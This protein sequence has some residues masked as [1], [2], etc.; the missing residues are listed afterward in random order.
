MFK[1]YAV[2]E[3]MDDVWRTLYVASYDQD[4][5]IT[6]ETA[7]KLT[8]SPLRLAVFTVRDF[9]FIATHATDFAILTRVGFP[10]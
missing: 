10:V 2:Q 1:I 6:L 8:K 7:K 4:A 3:F 5:E 9:D